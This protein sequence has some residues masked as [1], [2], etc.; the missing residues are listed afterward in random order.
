ME[1]PAGSTNLGELGVSGPNRDALVGRERE[2]A[3][4][5]EVLTAGQSGQAALLLVGEAGIGKTAL[6]RHAAE[7]AETMGYRVL[8]AAGGEVERELPHTALGDLFSGE[9]ERLAD[10]LP[11]SQRRVVGQ[12]LGRGGDDA[13]IEPRTVA[14]ATLDLIEQL[15]EDW[16]LA[17][18]LDD[19]HWLDPASGRALTFALRRTKVSRLTVVATQRRA[20]NLPL[21]L[22]TVWPDRRLTALELGPLAPDELADLLADRL[23][24]RPRPPV[25]HRVVELSDGHPLL[26]LELAQLAGDDERRLEHLDPDRLSGQAERII[27]QRVAD[28]SHEQATTLATVALM[29]GPTDEALGAL[30]LDSAG[31]RW[32]RDAGLL[33]EVDGRWAFAHPLIRSAAAARLTTVERRAVHARLAELVTDPVERAQHT[34]RSATIPDESA[35]AIVEA[36]A[37]EANRRG[38]PLE[39]ADLAARALAL[40]D[41]DARAERFERTLL[42]GILHRDAGD[43]DAA[44]RLLES[45]IAET[46]DG[47]QR[48]RALLELGRL[49]LMG[50]GP[51]PLERWREALRAAHS[52]A[53]RARIR[54]W[55]VGSLQWTEH[56][57]AIREAR[58]AVRDAERSGDQALL[59][60]CLA[61]AGRH[62]FQRVGRLDEALI[63]R[64]LALREVTHSGDT[65]DQARGSMMDERWP[66][67]INTLAGMLTWAG[68]FERAT[69]LLNTLNPGPDTQPVPLSGAD[70]RIVTI[71]NL[72]LAEVDECTG[73]WESALR[74]IAIA[75]HIYESVDDKLGMTNMLG[76]E[77]WIGAHRGDPDSPRLAREVAGAAEA[78][79]WVLTRAMAEASV[80]LWWL[81]EGNAPAA[82]THFE[83]CIEAQRQHAVVMLA[84]AQ[85]FPDAV[86][87]LALAGQGDDARALATESGRRTRRWEIPLQRAGMARAQAVL[88]LTE[89]TP[90]KAARRL[91]PWLDGDA[92]AELPFLRARAELVMGQVLRR[93]RHRTE[94]RAMLEQAR[95]GFATLGAASWRARAEEQL[96]RLG[97]RP[98]NAFSLTPTEEQIAELVAAGK[99]NREVAEAL[100]V[101][102]KTVEWNLTKVYEKVGVRSRAELAARYSGDA[103]LQV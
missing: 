92:L 70:A 55:L 83:R 84:E 73:R 38:A 53:L 16:P 34:A 27:G 17:L 46:P 88:A 68:D 58:L 18:V 10:T 64:V 45:A 66:E 95:E 49:E 71:G 59:A 96:A 6:S 102:V 48:A 43:H 39:G 94:A 24:R 101:S 77:A 42:A 61:A 57:G 79:G 51:Y 93:Q 98:G 4:I 75:E 74:R 20:R 44:H 21:R 67:T 62:A 5:H 54:L 91:R 50:G 60:N 2:R 23:G 30:G 32:A 7:Q 99:T 90:D 3:A 41:P 87:A 56:S 72:R 29:T 100:V 35:A 78:S 15:G 86:E 89:G 63:E 1:R 37:R 26:A 13:T 8:R 103:T 36:G 76:F 85:F 52:D 47:D 65:S 25:L 81:G 31:L 11:L 69:S 22:R 14:L 80:G 40:T 9:V 12:I 28:L 19:V 97:D 82:A 33:T